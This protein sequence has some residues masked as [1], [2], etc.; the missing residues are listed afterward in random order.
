MK[1]HRLANLA[2]SIIKPSQENIKDLRF[3]EETENLD[4][5]IPTAVSSGFRTGVVDGKTNEIVFHGTKPQAMSAMKKLNGKNLK[6][7]F[8]ASLTPSHK[9]GGKWPG[10]TPSWVKAESVENLDE[11]SI[12]ELIS[13]MTE[14]EAEYILMGGKPSK[15]KGETPANLKIAANKVMARYDLKMRQMAVD[16][17]K[18]T[19]KEET[20]NVQEVA[21]AQ[22]EATDPDGEM[23][24]TQL[25]NVV[26]KAMALTKMIQPN[27]KLEPWVQSK[28]TLADDYITTIHD[29]IKNTPGAVGEAFEDFEEGTLN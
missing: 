6:R 12:G 22:V 9:L 18:R 28:I 24:L 23:A 2:E 11:A 10:G 8:L 1:A 21:P 25:K 27:S 16:A 14:G 19:H 3:K 4:E 15:F 5:A 7:Y 17:Y 29:Y 13:K 26:N 20:E